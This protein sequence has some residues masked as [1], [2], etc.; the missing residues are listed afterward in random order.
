MSGDGCDLA[1]CGKSLDESPGRRWCK[2]DGDV[3]FD[4]TQLA[5]GTMVLGKYRVAGTLGVGGMAVVVAADHVGLDRRVAIKFLLP[6][7]IGKDGV[8]QRFLMEAKAAGRIESEH[9]AKVI[10]VGSLPHEGEQLPYMV[11]E[12]LDGQDLSLWVAEGHR[13]PLET[14]I[15]YALQAA[16]ALQLAHDRGIIHRDI[17]PANLF[18]CEDGVVKVLDFG[19]SKIL[20]EEPQE[21]SLTKTNAVLGSG[22]Y[23]SPEQ[24]RSAR[25]VDART[26]VYSLGVCL[27]ELSLIHI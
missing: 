9:V 12:Y 17:K 6:E 13:F 25:N 23:M 26:D 21:M 20:D 19:I 11:M 5:P 18:L 22:L 27:Y 2:V 24:M 15:D 16:E 7:M 14:A 4:P 1:P 10:D 3:S 8:I